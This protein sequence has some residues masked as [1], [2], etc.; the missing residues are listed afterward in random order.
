MQR[1]SFIEKKTILFLNIAVFLILVFS[2]I[3]SLEETKPV[4]K[5]LKKVLN[6]LNF[7]KNENSALQEKIDYLKSKYNLE[8]EIKKILGL[9]YEGERYII[10]NEETIQLP[11]EKSFKEKFKDLI[12]KIL[13]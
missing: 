12:K 1:K 4:K 5:E 9:G 2:F 10:V 11:Q 7:L 13:P 8:K 6:Q 3:K